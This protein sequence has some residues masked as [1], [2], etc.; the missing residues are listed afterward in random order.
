MNCKQAQRDIALW[1][2]HDLDDAAQ[3]EAVRRHVSGCPCCRTHYKQ[4]KHTLNV[5]ERAER[6]ATYVSGDSLWPELAAR[7]SHSQQQSARP[8]NSNRFNGWMPFIAMTAACFILLLV[9][10]EQPQ[11]PEGNIPRGMVPAPVYSP[12]HATADPYGTAADDPRFEKRTAADDVRRLN[13][14]LQREGNDGF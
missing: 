13:R 10:N 5:L 1:A 9:V 8:R 4:M 14:L 2:G 7:I 11:P 6:P 12:E 3:K